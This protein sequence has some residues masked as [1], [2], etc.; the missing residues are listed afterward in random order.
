MALGGA[1]HRRAEVELELARVG[2]QTWPLLRLPDDA[3]HLAR[4]NQSAQR[5]SHVSPSPHTDGD[6]F[7][8]RKRDTV[9][10]AATM[11]FSMSSVAR[12]RCGSSSDTT[13]SPSQMT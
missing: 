7:L 6:P 4:S 5:S 13:V 8:V 2:N 9:P 1:P 11:K 12:L 3:L 10:L